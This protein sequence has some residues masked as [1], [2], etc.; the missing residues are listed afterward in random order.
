MNRKGLTLVEVVLTALIV[1]LLATVAVMSVNQFL[2]EGKTRAA[3]GDLATL[4][5]A[6]R[7]YILDKGFPTAFSASDLV[8][9]AYIPEIPVDPFSNS[10]AHYVI[11]IRPVAGENR[12]FIGSRGPNG[13]IDYGADDI[14][15]Y[16]R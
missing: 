8:T 15:R 4:V 11:E 12:I 3:N 9:E 5:A 10:G 1:A 14:Y 2:I 13:V 6:T 7:L 16:V